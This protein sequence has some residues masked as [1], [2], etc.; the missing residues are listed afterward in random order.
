MRLLYDQRQLNL[1]LQALWT[2]LWAATASGRRQAAVRLAGCCGVILRV[3]RPSWRRYARHQPAP[4][5]RPAPRYLHE[6]TYRE[7]HPLPGPCRHNVEGM[8]PHARPLV[9][10][11]PDQ[12]RSILDQFAGAQRATVHRKPKC[13]PTHCRQHAP[14]ESAVRVL[15]RPQ[16]VRGIPFHLIGDRPVIAARA[17]RRR[18]WWH[19][20]VMALA[21]VL[22]AVPILTS[23]AATASAETVA[24]WSKR[25]KVEVLAGP[26]VAPIGVPTDEWKAPVGTVTWEQ[27]SV[28]KI[29]TAIAQDITITTN[30]TATATGAQVVIAWVTGAGAVSGTGDNGI[31]ASIA[32]AS[33]NAGVVLQYSNGGTSDNAANPSNTARRFAAKFLTLPTTTG[34]GTQWESDLSFTSS[35]NMRWTWTVNAGGTERINY[36]IVGGLT[37]AKAIAWTLPAGAGSVAVTTVGFTPDL[38]FHSNTEQNTV[39]SLGT[40][41]DLS[42]GVMNKHGQQF[43]NSAA[44]QDNISP[45]NTS[46]W[47]QTDACIASV[48]AGEAANLQGHFQ[49]MDATNDPNGF[50]LYFSACVGY[51][52]YYVASLCL[53]GV[54]S[55]I[56]SFTSTAGP[57]V[58]TWAKTASQGGTVRGAFFSNVSLGATDAATTQACWG[59]GA[60][61]GTTQRASSFSDKDAAVTTVTKSMW[62]S[63]ASIL[64]QFSGDG[65]ELLSASV[66]F[67]STTTFTATWAV[68]SAGAETC[69]LLIFDSGTNTWP[70]FSLDTANTNAIA[71][72]Y[73]NQKHET[74]LASGRMV[75]AR[76][77]TT[78]QMDLWYSDTGLAGSWLPYSVPIGGWLDGSIYSYTDTPGAVQRIVV[79]WKQSGTSGT[80]PTGGARTDEYCYC[81]V[82][83]LNAGETTVTWGAAV[84]FSGGGI[85]DY[86]PDLVAFSVGTGGYLHQLTSRNN[87]GYDY[88]MRRHAAIDSSGVIGAVTEATLAGDYGAGLPQNWPSVCLG[89]SNRL[90]A[91]WSAG[92]TGVGKGQ[93]FA[94]ATTSAG[95]PTWSG[96]LDL[97]TGYY[98][99]D[100]NYGAHIR[101]DP[102]GSQFVVAGF[103]QDVGA[104]NRVGRK[105]DVGITGTVSGGSTFIASGGTRTSAF[106]ASPAVDGTTGDIYVVAGDWND[107]T[108]YMVL[109]KF[110]R[111]AGTWTQLLSRSTGG[112]A[113]LGGTLNHYFYAWYDAGVQKVRWLGLAGNNAPYAIFQDELP[114]PSGNTHQLINAA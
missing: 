101:W 4:A 20:V 55:K 112:Q 71:T 93:R 111:V 110:D 9:D 78:T 26:A 67:T 72:G 48:T 99:P 1:A 88:V 64:G 8:G 76:G 17:P 3:Q 105:W 46:R 43:A 38:V 21:A 73:A 100:Q 39:G 14:R 77:T 94:Y 58:V 19:P 68:A 29:A 84:A 63:N 27:A 59:L 109:W 24:D 98:T 10:G 70:N 40:Q 15:W 13:R 25:S 74:T 104:A 44:S 66:A 61:D 12:V 32:Y 97:D 45:S 107:E 54:S 102:H 60:T 50:H 52:G 79:T 30:C 95:V 82:G 34:A 33:V 103:V 106:H 81:A 65:S 87:A 86:Y 62:R 83:T 6:F 11:R 28:A 51:S 36:V 91:T 53:A 114:L 56:G 113:L 5:A 7:L 75:Q 57:D 16:K 18:Q 69:Y 47:P 23:Y 90:G 22:L 2:L 80:G 96:D 31:A 42:F 108:S 85:R 92:T 49:S 89:A 41:L 37:A 35:T